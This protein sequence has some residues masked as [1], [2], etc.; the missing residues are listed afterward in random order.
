MA[1]VSLQVE[2]IVDIPNSSI[3]AV[4]QKVT[5]SIGNDRTADFRSFASSKKLPIATHSEIE[6]AILEYVKQNQASLP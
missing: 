2:M 3:A 6:L 4:V 5:D 1:Q